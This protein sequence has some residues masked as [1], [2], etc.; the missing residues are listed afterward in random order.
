MPT[1]V[2]MPALGE[3]VTEGTVTRWLKQEGEQVEVDEPLLEVSTDKVDTEIPSPA[4]GVLSKI[5]VAED[6][7]VEVGAELA[8]IGGD[9][10]GGAP[11]APPASAEDA[12]DTPQ[13]PTEQVDDTDAAGQQEQAPAAPAPSG[14]SGG[15]GGGQGTPVTM[16]ALGE[17]V[18]EGTVTRWLKSV[19]DEVTA[20]EPLLEVSTD[21]V[22]TE[23]PAP[24]SGTLLSISVNEDETVDVGAELAIIGS[25]AAGGGGGAPAPQEAPAQQ[26]APAQ[27]EAPA[28]QEAPAQQEAPAKQEAP[29][30]QP[31]PEPAQAA[32]ATEQPGGDYGSSGAQPTQS[33]TS[34]P[35]PAQAVA[36]SA[37][38]PQAGGGDGGGAYVT[39]LVRRLAAE[40]GVDLSSVTGT[41]VGGRIRKQDVLA[42]A[43]AASAP[44]PAA[45]PAAASAGAGRTPPK[46]SPAAMPDT[47]LRG[48]T[49][50]LSRLRTV[51][52]R[53]M[54]ESLAVS[55][56]LTTVVEADVTAIARLRAQAKKDFEAREGVK[57]SFLP[58]FA[59]SAVEALKAHPAVNSS[60]DLE[61]GTVTYHDS[62][63]LGV[64]VDT[65]RGLLVPVIKDAGDLSLAGIARKIA[66]LAERTRTNKVTPDELGG[67]TF[68]LT[69]TGSR[70]ALFDT[71]I[72]NQPQVAILG[73]GSVV[74]RPVVVQDE[75]LGEVIAVRSM[76]YLALTYDHRIVD[77]ADAA[78]FLTTV[79]ERLEAGQFHG[80]LG[81]A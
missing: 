11:A 58:F 65:D 29:A 16:P 80:E 28:K 41:G 81:L 68:T 56:Q 32:T 60:I 20:D 59:K 36:P 74:K 52:A 79:R 25:G 8:V 5:L 46:P 71:P 75:D 24:V 21:K 33:P 38:A 3:S 40:H 47:S 39:P 10:A 72:I 64:A 13:T 23:I 6:E 44:A 7:T 57:L 30:Q 66:D 34:A 76:V 27:E 69:N 77:G 49:E 54:V 62:E 61:A 17:S 31:T 50:K 51:I 12:T 35:A 73:T 55:A 15:S 4:A 45:A 43:E 63:N 67:G 1:S 78:R 2:T 19:G 14:D 9:G 53:R 42:A 70:G 48:R 18:T 26:Q 22:D 37:P